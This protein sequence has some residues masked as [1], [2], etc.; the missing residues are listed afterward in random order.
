[1]ASDR[2]RIQVLTE[3]GRGGYDGTAVISEVEGI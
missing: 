3:K 2:G 1:M